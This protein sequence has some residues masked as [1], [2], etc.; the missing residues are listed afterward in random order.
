MEVRCVWGV[1][2]VSKEYEK[3]L[4]KTI[5]HLHKVVEA[6]GLES[7]IPRIVF[8]DSPEYAKSE[9][10][11]LNLTSRYEI[12]SE[13]IW[14]DLYNMSRS[15]FFVGNHSSI[16]ML[17]ALAIEHCSNGRQI[18]FPEEWFVHEEDRDRFHPPKCYEKF[19]KYETSL[20]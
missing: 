16:Y 10:S 18:Y 14:S 5:E 13:N 7:K 4:E 17:S 19:Q 3:E 9:L 11:R 15:K 1:D 20:N 6:L 2:V 8:T 12:F